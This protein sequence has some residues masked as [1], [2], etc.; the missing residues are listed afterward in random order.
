VP[1][2]NPPAEP[3]QTECPAACGRCRR[4]EE[5]RPPQKV[6]ASYWWTTPDGE[7][8]ALC[9]SCTAIGREYAA[10]N[11]GIA[12]AQVVRITSIR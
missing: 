7:Q 6:R 10:L 4:I 9:E 5:D 2:I 8:V 3:E 11:P 12:E 1:V